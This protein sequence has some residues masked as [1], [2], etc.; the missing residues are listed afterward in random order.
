MPRSFASLFSRKKSQTLAFKD[1]YTIWFNTLQKP[2]LPLIHKS[3]SSSSSQTLLYSHVD[4]ILNH[5]FSYYNALNNA[6]THENL[7]DPSW[8]NI[9]TNLVRSH[10]DEENE[11]EEEDND[12]EFFDNRPWQVFMAWRNVSKNLMSQIE[13]IECG[14]RLIQR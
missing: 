11:E 7:P 8:R 2:L 1:Y 3:L 4:L 14:L 9:F 6:A 13:Q 12:D 5:F 10:L